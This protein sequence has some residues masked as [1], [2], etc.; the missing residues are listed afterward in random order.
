MKKYLPYFFNLTIVFIGIIFPYFLFNN[1]SIY[2]NHEIIIFLLISFAFT[3]ILNIFNEIQIRHWV[4]SSLIFYLTVLL[5]FLLGDQWGLDTR[6]IFTPFQIQH[7]SGKHFDPLPRLLEFNY[8][9]GILV[10]SL[11]NLFSQLIA[12]KIADLIKNRHN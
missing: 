2:E 1:S 10:L 3:I 11:L 4:C 12:S 7:H 8:P 6:S 5:I 9:I